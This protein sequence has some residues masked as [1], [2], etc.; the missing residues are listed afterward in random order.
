VRV[1]VGKAIL[2]VNVLV[3]NIVLGDTAQSLIGDATLFRNS[4]VYSEVYSGRLIDHYRRGDP[5]ER[6]ALKDP[7]HIGQR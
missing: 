1:Q 6:N 5:V 4:Q 3:E 2:S 7:I